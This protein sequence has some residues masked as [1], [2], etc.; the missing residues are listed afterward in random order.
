MGESVFT[1][2]SVFSFFPPDYALPSS[3]TLVGP[4]FGVQ[5]TTTTIARFNYVNALLY[6]TNGIAPD[7]SVA[8]STGTRVD[9]TGLQALAA[10]PSALVDKLDATMTHGTMTAGEKSAIVT[11][12][13]AI[14][15]TDT[16]GRARSAA[17]LVASSPRY[18]ITR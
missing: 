6:S 14:A 2:P 3:S 5:S 17:Y 16:L 12:V 13:S 15:A 10:T 4:Q 9:L 7:A 8:G 18:Q 1:A 11:A